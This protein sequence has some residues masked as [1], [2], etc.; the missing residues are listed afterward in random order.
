MVLALQVLPNG[1]K[2]V[3]DTTCISWLEMNQIPYLWW[4]NF[5]NTLAI[6][7]KLTKVLLKE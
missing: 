2:V 4:E 1:C 3:M 6:Q 5:V 7:E